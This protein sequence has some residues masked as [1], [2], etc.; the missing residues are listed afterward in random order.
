MDV[1]PNNGNAGNAVVN[2]PGI[3]FDVPVNLAGQP[4]GVYTVEITRKS[5]VRT[6]SGACAIGA[7]T[8]TGGTTGAAQVPVFGSSYTAGLPAAEVVTFEYRPWTYT[9][10]DMLG[11]GRI[12][13]NILP[14]GNGESFMRL[15]TTNGEIIAGG[16]SA[17]TFPDA[18]S[19][20]LPEDPEG[21]AED[22]ASCLPSTAV[23]CDPAL[24]CVPKVVIIGRWQDSEGLNAVFD[25]ESKAFIAVGRIGNAPHRVLLS[26]GDNNALYHDTL[27]KLVALANDNGIDLASILA[28]KVRASFGPGSQQLTVSLLDGLLI[29]PTTKPFGVQILSD[30]TA[31]AGLF[32]DL[33]VGA[34]GAPCPSTTGTREASSADDPAPLSW[35]KSPGVYGYNVTPMPIDLPLIQLTEDLAVGGPLFYL[36]ASGPRPLGFNLWL[37]ALGVDTDEDAPSGLPAW[38]LPVDGVRTMAPRTFEFIG[39]GSWSSSETSLG[40]T[41]CF[42]QG[43][44]TGIG[45]GLSNNPLKLGLDG[46]VRNLNPVLVPLVKPLMAQVNLAVAQLTGEV[47]ANPTIQDLIAQVVEAV[48][49]E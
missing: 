40:P 4:S 42:V 43:G 25:M 11:N 31:Q 16:L 12:Q 18:A 22:P 2:A 6:G 39:T 48:L 45:V 3:G 37:H 15:G 13:F 35:D 46:L 24:G 38:V 20:S 17:Y 1:P 36:K 9:F 5:V 23:A 19:F 14:G 49:G 8:P 7:P 34:N 30:F 21:C 41:A 44:F 26:L 47:T 33:Y 32:V 27:A 10:D 28:T 29:D